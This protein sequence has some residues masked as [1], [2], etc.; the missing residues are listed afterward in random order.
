M[1]TGSPTAKLFAAGATDIYQN[2]T[3]TMMKA[4]LLQTFRL[5]EHPFVCGAQHLE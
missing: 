2:L 5:S 4:T 3:W 1:K